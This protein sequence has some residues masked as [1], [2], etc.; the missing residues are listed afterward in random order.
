MNGISLGGAKTLIVALLGLLAP[1]LVAREYHWPGFIVL[2]TCL[3]ASPPAGDCTV[4]E[5]SETALRAAIEAGGRVRLCFDGTVALSGEITVTKDVHLDASG[6]KITISGSSASRLFHINSAVTFAATEVTFANGRAKASDTIAFGAPGQGGAFYN[7]GGQIWLTNCVLDGNHSIGGRLGG[8]GE[9]GAIFNLGGKVGLIETTLANNL[10]LGANGADL[11]LPPPSGFEAGGDA[12]GGAI[13]S[14]GGELFLQNTKFWSNSASAPHAYDPGFAKGGAIYAAG[15]RVLCSNAWFNGNSAV[16]HDPSFAGAGRGGPAAFGGAVCVEGGETVLYRTVLTGNFARGGGGFRHL[17]AGMSAGG[18]IHSTAM[19][20]RVEECTFSANSSEGGGRPDGAAFTAGE[21]YAGAFYNAGSAII[22]RTTLSGNRAMGGT[23]AF[24]PT[25]ELSGAQAFGGAIFNSGNLRLTNST[26]ALNEVIGGHGTATGGS[27]RG[28]ASVYG[29]GLYNG[30]GGDSNVSHSTIASNL[31]AR[32]E[33]GEPAPGPVFGVNSGNTNEARLV[34]RNTIIA[35]PGTHSNIHGTITDLGHNI[36]SD[37]SGG[38]TSPHS[39]SSTD[40]LLLPL[41]DNGGPTM[42]MR[43][44]GTSPALDKG[45]HN[46]APGID[47]RGI[48]RPQGSGFDIGAFEQESSF[49]YKG[50]ILFYRLIVAG[51]HTP[52]VI[53][54]SPT[55]FTIRFT[56]ENICVDL[57]ERRWTVVLGAVAPGAAISILREDEYFGEGPG[58]R[59]SLT[60]PNVFEPTLKEPTLVQNRVAFAVNH[61]SGANY[62][63]ERTSDFLTWIN[64]GTV[65]ENGIF[66]DN[67]AAGSAPFFYRAIITP[68]PSI[69]IGNASDWPQ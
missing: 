59:I 67:V 23:P 5:P 21:A 7:N 22:D 45:G 31:V 20:V 47:Q 65:S 14:Q 30:A 57:R 2:T 35:Y 44:Q 33:S 46:G 41:A 54:H 52:N 38:F 3:Q 60:V 12:R 27:L 34:L 13:F 63:I 51:C 69:P 62:A 40:P 53:R 36:C 43:L 37:G 6:R 64:A 55:S 25:G 66:H 1:N 42:T 24:P 49:V 19:N 29:G 26:I 48:D 39:L 11:A 32:V 50:G 8:D 56:R 9:G 18:A 68:K 15:A 17:A 16:F 4:S 28:R 61:F 58:W 10:A